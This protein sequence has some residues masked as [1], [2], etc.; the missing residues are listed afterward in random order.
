MHR[1]YNLEGYFTVD[2]T[3]LQFEVPDVRWGG[4]CRVEVQLTPKVVGHGEVKITANAKLFEGTSE[5]SNDLEDEEEITF[6]VGWRD[7]QLSVRSGC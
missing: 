5:D 2:D 6:K 7:V 3:A 4:E 1:K